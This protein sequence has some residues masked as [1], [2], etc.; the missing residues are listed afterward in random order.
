MGAVESALVELGVCAP[1]MAAPMAGG[2][3]TPD[4][5]AAAAA[6]GAFGF[7]AAG[8]LTTQALAG[9]IATTRGLTDRFGVNLFVPNPVPV[10]PVAFRRYAGALA[11]EALRY[12][13]DLSGAEIVEDDDAWPQKVDLLVA[14][15]VPLV[16]FTFGIPDGS[17]VR[18]LR[19][20]GSVTAQTVTC[21]QEAVAAREVGVDVLVVQAFTAGGHWGTL[22]PDRPPARR[23]LTELVRAVRSQVPLPV[24]AAGGMGTPAEITDVLGAGADAVVVGTVLLPSPESG[25]SAVHKAALV[26][27]THG[28]PTLTRA[29]SGRPARA[30]FNTFVSRFDPIAPLGYPAIHHLTSP[31]RRAAARAGDP[32]M[33][34]LWA[35]T[36]YRHASE[37]PVAATL[38]WLASEA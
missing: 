12:G 26:E 34:N 10:D 25:A 36:G 20:A 2:P 11:P 16:S 15:P 7:L 9:Q 33:V 32:E 4:L 5:V 1:V 31:L 30:L 23:P 27:G 21:V 38:N 29:F 8:Y 28:S 13:L 37:S 35:G 18:A 22:T 24:L 6:A 19:Q 14:D 17:V 3:S